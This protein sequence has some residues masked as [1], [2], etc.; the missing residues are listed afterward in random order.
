MQQL[1]SLFH[2]DQIS[3]RHETRIAYSRDASR[4][5]GECLAVVWP[6]TIED[7]IR[8]IG[9]AAETGNDLVPRG[10][11][12]GLCGGATPQ[13]SVVID[14]ARLRQI[15]SIDIPANKIVVEA[16]VPLDLLNRH[17]KPFELFFPVI[18]GSHRSATIG[19]MIATNAAGLHAVRYG[20]IDEWV[21][22]ATLIDGKGII[23]HLSAGDRGGI[24]GWE[25][26][27]GMIV[28]AALHLTEI[29][30]QRSL[31]LLCFDDLKGM[32]EEVAH[33]KAN[34]SL[35]A[36]EY[37]NPQAAALVGWAAKHTLL[38]EFHSMDGKVEATIDM[39]AIWRARESLSARL[40][41]AGFPISEDPQILPEAQESTLDWLAIQGIPVFG[42]LGVGIIHPRFLQGDPRILELYH[43]VSASGGQISGEHGMGLKK[44]QWA[45]LAMKV[46]AQALKTQFDPQGVFN[47]GKL[48]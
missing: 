43:R 7:M 6:E 19:G 37:I 30:Q 4:I 45:S 1:L 41:L 18:P 28:Q 13:N 34:P 12:T 25:G 29:P 36:L 31:T 5:H 8:L 22:E 10:A 2:P 11:G 27:T 26:I 24:A 44:R 17:L 32:L 39:A 14:S 47:R 16:G 38:A 46:K 23:H 48:C 35:S 15:G 42:H 3:I 9:W 40:T 20:R 21:A 33:L